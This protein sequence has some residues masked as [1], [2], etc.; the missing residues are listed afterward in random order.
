MISKALRG[1]SVPDKQLNMTVHYNIAHDEVAAAL[2][3]CLRAVHDRQLQLVAATVMGRFVQAVP[4]LTLNMTVTLTL[5]LTCKS[6]R[7]PDPTW[8]PLGLQEHA[9][10]ASG[11]ESKAW[12]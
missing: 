11:S 10:A 7:N 9:G 1:F 6:K 3:A 8:R 5:T 2:A 12:R 4:H